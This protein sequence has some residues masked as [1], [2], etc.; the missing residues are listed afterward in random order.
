MTTPREPLCLEGA[1]EKPHIITVRTRIDHS[2]RMRAWGTERIAEIEREDVCGY[3]F[4]SKS[5]SCGLRDVE[6]IGSGGG[7]ESIGA[8]FW[9]SMF[10]RHFPSVPVEDEKRLHDPAVFDDFIS[11][12]RAYKRTIEQA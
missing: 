2:E 1:P 11:R 6:I 7:V 4:K 5:P 12:I 3:I 10:M 9:A 8:G